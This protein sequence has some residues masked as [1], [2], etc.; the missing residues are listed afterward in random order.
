MRTISGLPLLPGVHKP[1]CTS[2]LDVDDCCHL[3]YSAVSAFCLDEHPWAGVLASPRMVFLRA[4]QKANWFCNQNVN[5]WI[6]F[7]GYFHGNYHFQTK[8]EL[9]SESLAEYCCVSQQ[10]WFRTLIF[11]LLLWC[12][13]LAKMIHPTR[14]P[15]IPHEEIPGSVRIFYNL[16]FDNKNLHFTVRRWHF[17]WNS[18]I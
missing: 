1:S 18:I 8:Y 14:Q 15:S 12:E 4:G 11:L 16:P 7:Y 3:K 6:D 9:F 5:K 10:H 2:R 17:S 13:Q